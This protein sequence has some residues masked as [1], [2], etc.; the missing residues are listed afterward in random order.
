MKKSLRLLFFCCVCLISGTLQAD[1]IYVYLK[2]GG[3]DVYPR[4][5]VKSYSEQADALQITLIND[6]V[7]VYEMSTVKSVGETP[8]ENMPR[9]TS[10]KFNNKYN[11][12]VYTDVI[13]TI[14][15][16]HLITATVG[17]IGKRLTPSFQVDSANAVVSVNGVKQV[18]KVSRNRFDGDVVYTLGYDHWKKMSYRKISDEIWSEP[19][20][21]VLLQRV[22]LRADMLSTNAPSNY[23]EGVEK[24][25]DG[26]PYTFFHST[27]GDNG[28]YAKLPLDE[29][30][31]I[32]IALDQDIQK[33][34]IGYTTRFDVGNRVPLSFLVQVSDDGLSWYDART[35]TAEDGVPQSG[36]GAMYNSPTITLDSPCKYIRFKMLTASYKNYLC[37]SELWLDEVIR[38]NGFTEP[39]LISPAKYEYSMVPYGRD[40]VVRVSWPTDTAAVPR[41]YIDVEGNILPPDK[42]NYLNAKIRIDGAGVY[43]DM[44]GDVTIKGRGNS[45]WAG[46]YGKS[47]Y[48]LKFAQS[49]KPFGLTKGKSWVLLA[50]KQTG[51]ML[52]NAVAMK[53][54]SMVETAGAN[55]IV[56]VELYMNG[57]YRGSY[58]FTQ[59]VGLSNNSID[60]ED[61]T[62]AVLLELDSYYDEDYKFTSDYYQL[63]VNVK[64]PDLADYADP[65]KQFELIKKDFNHFNTVLSY[66]TQE[67]A[68]LVDVEM[69]ARFLLV[70]EMVLNLELYHPKSTFLYKEDLL[71]LH[72][73]Y[74]FGPVWDFDWAFGY[75]LNYTYCIDNATLD[76]FKRLGYTK[77]GFFFNALRYNSDAVKRA[78]YANWKDFMELHKDELIEYVE[79]YYQYVKPSFVHNAEMWGDGYDYET[80]KNNTKQW[81]ATRAKYIYENC[82]EEVDLSVPLPVVFGDVNLDGYI[83]ISDVV[84]IMNY[85]QQLPN[86]TFDISQA[87]VDDNNEI[88]INDMVSCVA[89]VMNQPSDAI[90]RD[91]LSA[92]EAALR[93]NTFDMKVGEDSEANISFVT[94]ENGYKALQFDVMLP[95]HVEVTDAVLCSELMH[96]TIQ[97]EHLNDSVCRVLIYPQND[98]VLPVGDF[99]ITLHLRTNSMLTGNERVLSTHRALLSDSQGEDFRIA[100]HSA[101]FNYAPTNLKQTETSQ[102]IEGGDA[103]YVE[104]VN[105]TTISVFGVDGRCIRTEHLSVGKHRI[106]LPHGVYIVAGKKI[107]I[108]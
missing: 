3:L 4:D 13:A 86:E 27:W 68:Q 50:N 53:V 84:C 10:F 7:I 98:A 106:A 81:L 52:S 18:S 77:G 2:S 94:R 17:A 92:A 79:D 75:E 90:Y 72:S 34:R 5:V 25:I 64:D 39:E 35:L 61:E 104:T 57:E 22:E 65:D 26:D 63:P 69:L 105:D 59:H 51:S 95:P 80:V 32:D 60:I 38:E 100:P 9:F 93:V 89:L 71:A 24:T 82:I 48:R 8:P 62:N 37:L 73:R 19:G 66:S 67:Y 36:I 83:T 20:E 16:D 58:Q 85:L 14:E 12:Q 49:V 31:Y 87:D 45:S 54:A 41:V 101:R 55:R 30:P 28:P 23:D 40:V 33:F 43:P 96:H 97:A 78:Y 99:N 70:N 47:P 21:D 56:P 44:Q 15:N 11:D 102:L 88:T 1:E 108:N 74:V 76:Y 46:Q 107:I 91:K 42:E 29:C 6:S 103:L